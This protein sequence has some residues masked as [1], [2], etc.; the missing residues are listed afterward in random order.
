MSEEPKLEGPQIIDIDA[1]LPRMRRKVKIAGNEHGVVEILDL[2]YADYLKV[3]YLP[4]RLTEVK[5]DASAQFDLMVEAISKLVP[6]LSRDALEKMPL[7]Q[8]GILLASLTRA[9]GESA[10]PLA[11]TANA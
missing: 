3:S 11:P 2:P 4:Q 5:S 8:V 10:G 1:F 9:F 7:S 6:S